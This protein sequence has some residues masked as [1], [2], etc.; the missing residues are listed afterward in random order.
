M[1]SAKELAKEFCKD[2][3]YGEWDS[4]YEI[5]F[6]AGFKAATQQQAQLAEAKEI[7]VT[8]SAPLRYVSDHK[9]AH[10]KPKWGLEFVTVCEK[11]L[12]D[13]ESGRKKLGV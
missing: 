5:C 6:L 13:T 3:P 10:D 2:V 9:W 11:A 8:L 12:K 7:I 1:K 4:P